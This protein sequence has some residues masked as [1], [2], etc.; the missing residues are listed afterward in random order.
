MVE[1]YESRVGEDETEEGHGE[2]DGLIRLAV[3]PQGP[4]GDEKKPQAKAPQAEAH[5]DR[6]NSEYGSGVVRS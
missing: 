2:R 1:T 3:L 5:H 6:D 4:H